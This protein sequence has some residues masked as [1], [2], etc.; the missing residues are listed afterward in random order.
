MPRLFG[1]QRDSARRLQRVADTSGLTSRTNSGF[2]LPVYP[3]VQ[4]A[5]LIGK[6]DANLSTASTGTMSIYSDAAT[7]SGDNVTVRN[8]TGQTLLSGV[9]VFAI[10]PDRWNEYLVQ[11]WELKQC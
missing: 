3:E 11:P 4:V 7:D 8:I 10:K 6:L 9:F 2:A 5:I 1:F